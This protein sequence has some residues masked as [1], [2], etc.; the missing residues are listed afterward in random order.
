MRNNKHI[1][2][3]P[4]DQRDGMWSGPIRC[5]G[6]IIYRCGHWRYNVS[7]E[8]NISRR[9]CYDCR[10]ALVGTRIDFIRYGDV[11]ES[12]LSYNYTDN[13]SESGVSVY[14]IDPDT[15]D[16]DQ[17]SFID[18]SRPTIRGSAICIGY[19]SDDEPIIDADTIIYT[20]LN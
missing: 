15:G 8:D 10:L 14:G 20:K 6:A 13:R 9:L 5:K 4:I 12:G 2:L 1:Y 11:P 7:H 18:I 16:A 17:F 3:P 19:G